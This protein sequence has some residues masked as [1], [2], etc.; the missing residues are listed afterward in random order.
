MIMGGWRLESVKMLGYLIFPIGAFIY[1]NSPAF[2]EQSLRHAMENVSK[3]INL[4]NLAKFEKLN[5]K[6]EIDKL[7][8]LIDELDDKKP[9]S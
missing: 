5:A 4:E 8:Y 3:D 9:K 1:F 2:Y 6:E 7:S